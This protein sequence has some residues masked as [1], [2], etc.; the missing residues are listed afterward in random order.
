MNKLKQ[1]KHQT[2]RK[3]SIRDKKNILFNPGN[4]FSVKLNSSC[5]NIIK[6]YF[7]SPTL[8]TRIIF[9]PTAMLSNV[10]I[11]QFDLQEFFCITS[12]QLNMFELQ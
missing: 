8:I 11:N 6:I 4:H 12:P 10:Y 7:C 2:F 5:K 3:N 1:I 9:D